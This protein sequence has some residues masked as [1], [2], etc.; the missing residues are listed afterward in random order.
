MSADPPHSGPLPDCQLPLKAL[1]T[2]GTYTQSEYYS[3]AHT[4][5]GRG[6]VSHFVFSSINK[7]GSKWR[8]GQSGRGERV[9][10]QMDGG[11]KKNSKG[12]DRGVL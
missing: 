12:A 2:H 8:E 10:V 11:T 1:Q 3:A 9:F 6:S 5:G 7:R 4:V